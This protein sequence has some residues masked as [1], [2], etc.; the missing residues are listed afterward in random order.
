MD[1][2][3]TTATHAGMLKCTPWKLRAGGQKS[4]LTKA[5]ACAR[6]RNWLQDQALCCHSPSSTTAR[7]NCQRSHWR[8]K[9]LRKE[10]HLY[11][12]K[13]LD[14]K[15]AREGKRV[16]QSKFN[17]IT[18]GDKISLR[19]RK[20][21]HRAKGKRRRPGMVRKNMTS[22]RNPRGGREKGAVIPDNEGNAWEGLK[23][24]E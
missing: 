1:L 7:G 22:L 14:Q 6:C 10:K 23:D 8:S 16:R 19:E 5:L 13:D 24:Q 17:G 3:L 18:W 12:N 20:R 15:H 2:F 9:G 4:P 11:W 21:K